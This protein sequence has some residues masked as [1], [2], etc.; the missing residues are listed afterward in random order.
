MRRGPPPKSPALRVVE[1]G[2]K[3]RARFVNRDNGQA[4]SFDPIGPPPSHLTDQQAAT[5]VA[6]ADGAP[7]GT[8]AACDRALLEAFAVLSCAHSAMVAQLNAATPAESAAIVRE[9]RRMATLMRGLAGDL[10]FAP[11]ARLRQS[12]PVPSELA[13]P[14]ARFFDGPAR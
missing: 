11:S 9:L 8:L 2:N 5:W 6:L 12:V 7:A 13:D 14:T 10:G 1:S 3:V 4:S